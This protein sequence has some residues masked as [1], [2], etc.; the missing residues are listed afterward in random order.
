[1]N[2]RLASIGLQRKE[3]GG[4][5][6]CFYDSAGAELGLSGIVVR[7]L[8]AEFLRSNPAENENFVCE[9]FEKFCSDVA[10]NGRNESRYG[11]V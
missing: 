5:G 7:E 8:A 2:K 1:M 3:R 6:N 4:A 11:S 9:P 10:T